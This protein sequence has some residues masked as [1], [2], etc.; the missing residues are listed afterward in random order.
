MVAFFQLKTK[1]IKSKYHF[2][3]I[4]PGFYEDQDHMEEKQ[5]GYAYA[6]LEP[7]SVEAPNE[8]TIY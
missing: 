2:H 7:G 3:S 1:K 4:K 6:R 5:E 8:A